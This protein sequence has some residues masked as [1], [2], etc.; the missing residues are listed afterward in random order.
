MLAATLSAAHVAPPLLLRASWAWNAATEASGSQW[1]G[2]R[3]LWG[4]G[5][6]SPAQ[7]AAAAASA[8][9]Q[10][11][12]VGVVVMVGAYVLDAFEE[13]LE[14]T[15]IF[16]TITRDA[17]LIKVWSRYSVPVVAVSPVR[18]SLQ[19]RRLLLLFVPQFV[20]PALPILS[21]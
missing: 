13:Q 7:T 1:G 15:L 19:R 6:L 20:L 14:R 4:W 18:A 17:G 2:A 12:V 21:R 9:A 16:A 3:L 8:L 11:A 5:Y 10:L